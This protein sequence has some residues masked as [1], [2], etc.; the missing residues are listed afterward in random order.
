MGVIDRDRAIATPR[1]VAD[2]LLWESRAGGDFGL[3]EL[4]ELNGSPHTVA[5]CR[6]RP[7][8]SQLP[9]VQWHRACTIRAGTLRVNKVIT[10][11][12]VRT[13]SD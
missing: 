8:F 1:H 13:L 7:E 9:S 3:R 4:Q 11:I 2:V 12:F 5:H 10:T 6:R